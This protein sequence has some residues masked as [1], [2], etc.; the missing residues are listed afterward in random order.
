VILSS[1]GLGGVLDG[2]R[3]ASRG[4]SRRVVAVWA[5]AAGV[6]IVWLLLASALA[7]AGRFGAD[8]DED[9]MTGAAV[10]G[11]LFALPAAVLSVPA[12]VS[13]I[14]ASANASLRRSARSSDPERRRRTDD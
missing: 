13:S 8:I 12:F 4:A 10:A 14:R 7:I 2:R 1:I 5:I 9:V 3:V 11:F 6:S